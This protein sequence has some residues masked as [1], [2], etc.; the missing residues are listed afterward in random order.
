M[1]SA[2]TRRV[3]RNFKKLS[4]TFTGTAD[5]LMQDS[6]GNTRFYIGDVDW[7][8]LTAHCTLSSITG[9]SATFKVLTSMTQ[10]NTG[11]T[12][13]LAAVKADGST[14]FASA[15]LASATVVGIATGRMASTGAAASNI[16]DYISILVDVDTVS[17]CVATAQVLVR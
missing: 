4:L 1:A 7:S 6:N 16:G 14:A 3:A 13:D 8:L 15:S 10:G 2:N 17:A 12:T 11:A 9:T 5:G